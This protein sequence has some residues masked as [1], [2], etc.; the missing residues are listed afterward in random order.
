MSTPCIL[1]VTPVSEVQRVDKFGRVPLNDPAVFKE[2]HRLEEH[3]QN[4]LLARCVRFG[5][6]GTSGLSFVT[7]DERVA[8]SYGTL[9]ASAAVSSIPW[10]TPMLH[11]QLYQDLAR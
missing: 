4:K 10:S 6:C 11:V 5:T 8:Q 2:L 9:G 1:S 3:L 7:D